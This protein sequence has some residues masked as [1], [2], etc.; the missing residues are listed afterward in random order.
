[1]AAKLIQGETLPNRHLNSLVGGV[2]HALEGDGKRR[3]VSERLQTEADL[4]K[5]RQVVSQLM[6]L[7]NEADRDRVL[8]DLINNRRITL[9]QLKEIAKRMDKVAKARAMLREDD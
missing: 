5:V 2:I 4:T 3:R 7:P 9:P 1:M 8:D 6:E